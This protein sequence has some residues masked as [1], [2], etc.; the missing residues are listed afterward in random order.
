MI[1]VKHLIEQYKLLTDKH[2]RNSRRLSTLVDHGLLDEQKI[3]ML[4]R[5]LEKNPEQMT[6]AEKKSLLESMDTLIS[7]I[8]NETLEEAKQNHLSKFDKRSSAKYPKEG[9]APSVI[10]LQRKAIRV[11]PDN[12]KIALYYSQALDKYVSIPFGG[13]P[14]LGTHMNEDVEKPKFSIAQQAMPERLSG[15]RKTHPR[16]PKGDIQIGTVMSQKP[17]S[18]LRHNIAK[19][20]IKDEIKESFSK[21][22]SVIR[23]QKQLDEIAPV[24]AA[25]AR[26]AVPILAKGAMKLG[27]GLRNLA[28]KTGKGLKAVGAGT[29]AA[30][31]KALENLAADDDSKD[32]KSEPL[33]RK[34]TGAREHETSAP[35]RFGA[36]MSTTQRA[37]VDAS[38]NQ[39]NADANRKI[40]G[41]SGSPSSPASGQIYES[42]N[43]E[44]I[45]RLASEDDATANIMFTE[46]TVSINSIIAKKVLDVH[47][48]LNEDNKTK[49]EK[50]INEDIETFRKAINFCSKASS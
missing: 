50:M 48:S 11:F 45:Q 34:I 49:M 5:A 28:G 36:K 27:K 13:A 47:S 38:I 40:F 3:P 9:E 18:R 6:M 20:Y 16:K 22:L 43:F 33:L 7:V 44:I 19:P 31:K 35:G 39:A 41:K 32:S 24:V 46:N 15:P 14:V 4:K 1:T 12:Q 23:E 29:L 26:V 17:V 25:A 8:D 42:S 21:K 30:G 10:I 2:D 37:T